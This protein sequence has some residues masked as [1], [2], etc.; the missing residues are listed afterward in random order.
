MEG[1]ELIERPSDSMDLAESFAV[2]ARAL[3]AEP[4][5]DA[6]LQR[7][8]DT[9]VLTVPGCDHAGISLVERRRIATAAASD[10]VPETVDSIQY[11]TGSG[12][13]V[14]AIREHEA[15][16]V[17]DLRAEDRWPEFS[18]R[19]T[20]A[21]GV[22]SVLSLRLF[23]EQDTMGALNL[24]SKEPDA[25]GTEAQAIAAVFA[26]HASV[27][28]SSSRR[29]ANLERALE[30]RDVIGQAKGILIANGQLTADEAFEALRQAS[31]NLNVKLRDVAD[32]VVYT[33]ELPTRPEER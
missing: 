10:E 8:V 33:G 32:R 5:A 22:R 28:M 11:E 1:E 4:S 6:V 18:Q 30:S 20:E 13:L 23:A 21:T 27:A 14:D 2:I 17:D 16:L 24:Y 9:A 7:I 3:L 29:E 31:R 26:A 19:A 15:I 25:F 12:P